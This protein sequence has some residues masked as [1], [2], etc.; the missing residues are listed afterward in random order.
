MTLDIAYRLDCIINAGGFADD[1]EQ[2]ELLRRA[3]EEILRL[4]RE[5]NELNQEPA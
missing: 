5:L 3:L 2:D 1:D 4:R